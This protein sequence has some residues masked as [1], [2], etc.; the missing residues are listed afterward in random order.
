MIA[1]K[2]FA[3]FAGLW[4]VLTANDPDAWLLGA[5]TAAASTALSLRLLPPGLRRVHLLAI[6]R[7]VLGFLMGSLQGGI[8][9]ARRAIDPRLPLDPGWIR[10][11]HRLPPGAP[12]AALGGA[13]SLMPGT[14]AAG[15]DGPD[16]LVHCLDRG[17]PVSESVAVEERRLGAVI[18][19]ELEKGRA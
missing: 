12:R 18:G 16:L 2:R 15:G 11:P 4:L 5:A 19:I 8:D 1:L 6:P 17:Q 13:L 3:F 7:L 10:Y 9:V 14:L